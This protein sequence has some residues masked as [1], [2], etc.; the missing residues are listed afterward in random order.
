[1]VENLTKHEYNVYKIIV[2][3]ISERKKIRKKVELRLIIYD[4]V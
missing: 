2:I 3:G 1:M 4:T